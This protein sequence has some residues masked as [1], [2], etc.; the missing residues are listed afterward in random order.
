MTTP[1]NPSSTAQRLSSARAAR[2]SSAGNVREP[3]EAAGM[4]AFRL[5]HAVV[6]QAAGGEVRLIEAGAA[7]EHRDV[8]AGMVHHPHMR[9][10]IGEQRIEAVV[11]IA[12]LVEA[13]GAGVGAALHQFRR[14][15]VMLKVDDHLRA[16]ETHWLY[17][18]CKAD[19]LDHRLPQLSLA[20]DEVG[21]L[22]RRH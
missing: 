2:G 11:G 16:P 10:K 14:R 18:G 3:D 15:V 7:G 13:K 21:E 19:L 6:D 1:G 22:L 5:T 17:C 8:D 4:I 9:G 12:V 20:A